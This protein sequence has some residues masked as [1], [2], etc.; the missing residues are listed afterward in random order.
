MFI[1]TIFRKLSSVKWKANGKWKA[2][3]FRHVIHKIKCSG[4]LQ[5]SIMGLRCEYG[6]C[7]SGCVN[8]STSF[9]VMVEGS[10]KLR[11]H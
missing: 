2:K 6:Q 1:I 8:L 4:N 5:V 11:L 10:L 7:K 3:A 9:M